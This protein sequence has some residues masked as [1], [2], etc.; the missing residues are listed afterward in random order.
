M[1]DRSPYRGIIVP[2]GERE[3]FDLLD[4]DEVLRLLDAAKEP[5]KTL[6]ATLAYSGLRLGE[7]LGLKW[8]DIDFENQ[9]ISIHSLRHFF[10]TTIFASGCSIKVLQRSL[11]HSSAIMTLDTC[12]HFIPESA[13]ESVTRF[14]AL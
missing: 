13:A 9:C 4:A 3:E 2:K 10:A 11:G 5:E 6:F 14:D 12:A 1:L 7:A 8:R